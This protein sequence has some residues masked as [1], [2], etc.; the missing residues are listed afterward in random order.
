MKNWLFE[1]D[2]DNATLIMLICLW[3][4]AGIIIGYYLM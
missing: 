4:S 1:K 2:V 3:F